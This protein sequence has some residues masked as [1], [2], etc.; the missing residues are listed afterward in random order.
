MILNDLIQDYLLGRINK[1]IFFDHIKNLFYELLSDYGFLYFDNLF[2]YPFISEL[3]D[4][5]CYCMDGFNELLTNI[6]DILEGKEVY[7]YSTWINIK[8][9]IDKKMYNMWV[10]I[11]KEGLPRKKIKIIK[12]SIEKYKDDKTITYEYVKKLSDLLKI[13]I[14]DDG[15]AESNSLYV[16]NCNDEHIITEIDRMFLILLG[17]QPTYITIKYTDLGIKYI[18]V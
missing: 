16:P 18:C 1:N 2:Y 7:E 13:L 9:V 12:D 5:D 15:F 4:E 14:L 11:K 3:M 6:I 10:S 8:P 17:E